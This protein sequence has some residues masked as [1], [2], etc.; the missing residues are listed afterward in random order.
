MTK[1]KRRTFL[2]GTAAVLGSATVLGPL[3]K[4]AAEEKL[5]IGVVHL[6][7]IGDVGWEAQHALAR[8]AMEDEYAERVETTV[9]T[10]IYQHRMLNECSETWQSRG[11]SSS[12]ARPF[13]RW[14][15]C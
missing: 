14:R 2:K 6:G 13:R 4:I 15:P 5:R 10:E 3:Q 11:T 1:L 9:V 8:K 12:S 7:P